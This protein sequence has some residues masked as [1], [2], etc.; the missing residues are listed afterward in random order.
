MYMFDV[1]YNIAVFIVVISV[2]VFVHEFGH[3]FVARLCGVRATDFSIG[4]GKKIFGFKDKSGTEWKISAIPLG[5]YV[6]FLGDND[7]ASAQSKEIIPAH[8]RK[9]AFS[10]QNLFKKS[11]IVIAGPASN[12][13]FAI[14]IF[15]GFYMHFGRIVVSTEISFI[16][17]GSVADKVGLEKGDIIISIDGNKID[18]FSDVEMY[19]TTHPNISLKFAIDRKGILKEFNIIPRATNVENHFGENS[20]IGRLGIGA[21]SFRKKEYGIFDAVK[22]AYSES[23]KITKISLK[24][25]GQMITGKRDT[26]DL[27]SVIR[28]SKYAGKIARESVFMLVWFSAMISLNLGLVN[29]FPVPPLDGGHLFLY[30]SRFCLGEKKFVYVEKWLL[31]AGIMLIVLLMVF[32]IINDLLYI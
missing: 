25:L 11:L 16:E 13:I 19:V 15:A 21:S 22:E 30:A 6:K 5:G 20:K 23:L 27:S 29:L 17:K 9:Y 24:A 31:K 8:L 26:K 1:F 14:I 10:T 7:S 12:F 3:Y 32:S 2:I 18:Q 4:F 28:I